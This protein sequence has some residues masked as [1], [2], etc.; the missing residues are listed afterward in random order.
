MIE[1][2]AAALVADH[3][4]KECDFLSIGTNDLIQFSLAIDR[5]DQLMNQFY[6]PA[7]PS[8]IRLIKL[9]V[10]KAKKAKA[11]VSVC[12]EI[13]TDPRF[14]ALLLGL[15][16]KELS[17]IP[18]YLPLIKEVIR[19]TTMAD[20]VKLANKALRLTTAEEILTLLPRYDE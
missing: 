8:I 3:L 9:V 19:N 1:V 5:S 18:R 6:E 4:A 13:A 12:G 20:A 10:T 14:T 7:D 11:P 2:P 15:G 17:V 16:V